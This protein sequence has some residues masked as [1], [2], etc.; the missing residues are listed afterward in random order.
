[1]LIILMLGTAILYYS[2]LI[3]TVRPDTLDAFHMDQ[4]QLATIS[5]IGV[6]PGAVLSIFVGNI[7]DRK[8]IKWFVAISMAL[9][10]FF[11]FLRILMSSYA[12]LLITT[13]LIG[14]FLLPII[15]VGPKMIGN[16]FEP[17]DIPVAMG[18]FGAAGGIG[19][20]LAF[21]TGP[22]YPSIKMSL[23]GVAIIGAVILILWMLFCKA[24]KKSQQG[25]A[26]A[27]PKGAFGR[28]LRSKNLWK[29]MI[30]GGCAIGAALIVNTS[31]IYGFAERGFDASIL[32]TVLNICLIIGGIVSGIVLGKIGRFNVPYLLMCVIGGGAYLLGW[33]VT[34][35]Y[36]S[37][38][39]FAIGGII[40]SG[41]VGVNFTKIPLLPLT[42]EF[43]PEMTG[44]AS[45]MLQTAL[46]I[47]QFVIPTVVAAIA[48]TSDGG[49]N[50]TLKF[51]IVFALLCVAGILG[52]TMPEL[53]IKGKLAQDAQ[54]KE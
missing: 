34:P 18:C 20:T 25:E 38:V 42:H 4:V 51:I 15:I 23:A 44:A 12:G 43:A 26:P 21:A 33:L 27:L 16:L 29:T 46:G 5:T 13:I 52:M 41:S 49:T 48:V 11:M 36:A 2:N 9:A 17:K 6:I 14:T 54:E 47:F 24:D 10:V 1:M 37:Y 35:G 39:F 53:G 50:F 22:I 28:V 40:A 30:C 3:F 31:L 8:S 32:G 7:L 45:G 19:T